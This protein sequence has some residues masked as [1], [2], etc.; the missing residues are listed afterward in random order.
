[1][2]LDRIA[3]MLAMGNLMFVPSLNRRFHFRCHI[4]RNLWNEAH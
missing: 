4:K 3:A 1:M 2:A